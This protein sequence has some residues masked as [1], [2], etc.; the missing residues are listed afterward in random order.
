MKRVC[1]TQAR[2]GPRSPCPCKPSCARRN[3]GHRPGRQHCALPSLLGQ[4]PGHF[5]AA[6]W[7]WE[8]PCSPPAPSALADKSQCESAAPQGGRRLPLHCS[9]G[10]GRGG[11]AGLPQLGHMRSPT[12]TFNPHSWPGPGLLGANH[13]PS[14]KRPGWVHRSVYYLLQSITACVAWTRPGQARQRK[15]DFPDPGTGLSPCEWGT[16]TVSSASITE[17]RS[18]EINTNAQ[19]GQGRPIH[20]SIFCQ[21]TDEL[22]L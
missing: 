17:Q 2:P 9:G 19:L 18:R 3:P 1:Q 14:I 15:P 4:L 7:C 20:Y 12:V 22:G 10:C 13:V 16:R 11:H 6:P 8:V 21:E 5:S